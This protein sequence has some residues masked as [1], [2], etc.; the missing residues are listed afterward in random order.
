MSLEN[1]PAVACHRRCSVSSVFS[2]SF[3]LLNEL[4]VSDHSFNTQ[5]PGRASGNCPLGS[6]PSCLCGISTQSPR[7]WVFPAHQLPG[8]LHAKSL[9]LAIHQFQLK[10]ASYFI[11]RIEL[12]EQDPLPLLPSTPL[13]TLNKHFHLPFQHPDQDSAWNGP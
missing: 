1:G 8:L 6:T 4:T 12:C 10:S 11:E 7:S 13:P 9:P 5:L 3:P 2:L